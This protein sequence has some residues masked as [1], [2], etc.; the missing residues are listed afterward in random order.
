MSTPLSVSRVT[1][2]NQISIPAKVRRKF[3]IVPGTEL[4]WEE[5]EG[6]LV[7]RPKKFTLEDIQSLCADRPVRKRN[8]AQIRAARDHALAAKYARD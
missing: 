1:A 8:A 4:V 5:R 6:L 7:V 2:Q 3:H